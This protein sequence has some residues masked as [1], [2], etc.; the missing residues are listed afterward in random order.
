VFIAH[1]VIEAFDIQNSVTKETAVPV[2][3][4]LVNDIVIGKRFRDVLK[5]CLL[6]KLDGYDPNWIKEFKN[7]SP[8]LLDL[9]GTE[10][11]FKKIFFGGSYMGIL[12]KLNELTRT[13]YDRF[14]VYAVSN[15]ITTFLRDLIENDKKGKSALFFVGYLHLHMHGTTIP[16]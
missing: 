9:I 15:Q 8:A 4:V 14:Y 5:S 10:N 16:S 6:S 13:I 2:L 12:P 7:A 11:L 1:G 3:D